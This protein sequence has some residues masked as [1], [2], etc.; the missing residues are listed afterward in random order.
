MA[1]ARPSDTWLALPMAWSDHWGWSTG[2]EA[3]AGGQTP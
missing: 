1:R 2:Y 3:T